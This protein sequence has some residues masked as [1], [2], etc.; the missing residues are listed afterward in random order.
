VVQKKVN[1]FDYNDIVI[2]LFAFTAASCFFYS[3]YFPSFLRGIKIGESGPALNDPFFFIGT[4]FENSNLKSNYMK[5]LSILLTLFFLDAVYLAVNAQPQTGAKA[6][7]SA[8]S[9]SSFEGSS[10]TS[11]HAGFFA[12]LKLNKQWQFQPEILYSGEG[13][14][15]TTEGNK[16]TI[17]LGYINLPM[18]V[19]YFP[20]EKFYL[21]VGPQIGF[22]AH[23]SSS[24][25]DVGKLNVKRSFNNNQFALVAGAGVR[26]NNRITFY[27]RYQLG[28]S[29][30][31]QGETVDHSRVIMA[32]FSL[33]FRK[34]AEKK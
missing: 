15:Y 34:K 25:E 23:A 27:G 2:F 9:L 19:R 11:I 8:A 22:L 16:R 5:K 28:L 12:S 4:L 26:V 30:V 18:M 31:T 21:E 24:G 7:I 10:R 33:Q 1:H 14:Q 20:A 3:S 29:D 17:S 13:Q 32:G 6:G